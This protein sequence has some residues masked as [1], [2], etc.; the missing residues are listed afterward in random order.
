MS[1]YP[2]NAPLL[3]HVLWWNSG[4]S[5]LSGVLCMVLAKPLAHWIAPE[6]T[7]FGMAFS[8]L[9]IVLG[10][11]LVCFAGWVY[12]VASREPPHRLSSWIIAVL[13][14]DWV[15]GSVVLLVLG[16]EALSF[17]GKMIIGNI[18]LIVAI[19]AGLE[20]VALIRATTWATSGFHLAK[21]SDEP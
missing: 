8:T 13:D 2:V 9:L 21:S 1:D 3:R 11:G 10:A 7:L 17:A 5:M 16:G 19:F 14:V 4:F 18:A 12:V 15:I 20:L 6:L